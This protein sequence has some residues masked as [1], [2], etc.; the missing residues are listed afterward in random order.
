MNISSVSYH[1]DDLDTFIMNRKNKPKFIEISEC[2]IKA[3][4]PLL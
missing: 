4:R 3:G 2:R 1:I